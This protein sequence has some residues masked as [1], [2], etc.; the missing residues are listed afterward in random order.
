MPGTSFHNIR[1][2]L[3]VDRVKEARLQ[4][5]I[6][7]FKNLK[8]S[9]NDTIDAYATKLSGI[10][11]K[12]TTLGEVMSEHKLVK[13]FLT[14]L[15]R[16]FVHIVAALEQV[17]DLKTTGFEDVVGRLK[18]YEERVKEEDKAND[19]QKNF[20][21]ARTEY[22]SG[23]NNSSEARG[24]G[25]YSRDRGLCRETIF[26][27][28]EKYTPP[29]SESNT[30][31]DDVWYFDNGASNHMTD[32]VMSDSEDSTVTYTE[33]S[34]PF[35]DLSDIGSP[36]VD[37]LP[38]MP[39]DPYAYVVAAFQ[40]PP[41]PDYVTG[42]KEPEQAPPSPEFVPKPVYPEFMPP[43]DEEDEEDPE[44]DPTDYPT[45]RGDDDESFNDDED[46]DDDVKEDKDEEEEEE[47]HPALVDSVPPPVYR[48]MAR[49]FI[50]AQTPISLPSDIKVARLLAIPT[51]PPSPLSPFCYDPAESRDTIY[52]PSTTIEYPP[53]GTPPLLPIPLPT[54][55]P[56]LLLPSTVCRAGVSE[57]TPA[58][59][60][61]AELSQRMT[62]FV[63][64][65]RHDTY[66]LYGRLDDAQDDRLLM[67]GQLIML[68]RDRRA[69]TRSARL[70]EIGAKLS[71]E[72][73]VQ[74]M[75]ASDTTHSEVRALRTTVLA[76]Q[77]EIAGLRA[78]DRT[79]QAQLVETL[80]LMR[81]L[82]THVTAL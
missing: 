57:G 82:Q 32:L 42:P 61:V 27:N 56:P 23:N 53:S 36:G 74:S 21:Y 9:D 54:P 80:T 79:R 19:A 14:S 22:S 69:H 40:A 64:T 49:M 67:S 52:F 51:P 3:G 7:E 25:S 75:D 45:D 60:D 43:E 18:A 62:D 20:L 16:R 6:T 15:P 44:E 5:L 10:A 29:K 41:S 8:M 65:V 81:T 59:T 47:E 72:A 35:E 13:K 37:G 68:R 12:S 30:D 28:E 2:N 66:E 34:S 78:G 70:M 76:Q 71:R 58:V 50:R 48:V 39:E 17:L 31:E 1:R 46:D 33:V 4:T 73:W 11:S 63:T 24:R 26:M 77:T 38:I 55:S